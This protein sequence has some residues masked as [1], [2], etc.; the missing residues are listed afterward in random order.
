M[1]LVEK[2]RTR[3]Y[4]TP[5]TYT[6]FNGGINTNLS[7]EDLEPNELRDGLNCHY[8]NQSLMNRKGERITNRLLLPIKDRPQG[9]FL[10][11]AEHND[12]ILCVRNGRIYWNNYN[13]NEKEI[14]MNLLPLDYVI[15]TNN[16]TPIR[17]DCEN[18]GIDLKWRTTRHDPDSPEDTEGYILKY[19]GDGT[20]EPSYTPSDREAN[21]T[22]ICQNTRR[23]QAVPVKMNMNPNDSV[24]IPYANQEHTYL[25]MATGTRLLRIEETQ[26]I[27]TNDEVFEPDKMY[28]YWDYRKQGWV[29]LRANLDYTAGTQYITFSPTS[30]ASIAEYINT[31]HRQV[32]KIQ[33]TQD[34]TF[35]ENETY[36]RYYNNAYVAL[37]ADTDYTVGD[38]IAD[39]EEDHGYK[40]Y[41]TNESV[42]IKPGETTFNSSDIYSYSNGTMVDYFEEANEYVALTAGTNYTVGNPIK[43]YES[44]TRKL[45]YKYDG[46]LGKYVKPDELTF[47]SGTNYFWKW[48]P[49]VHE[50]LGNEV[51]TLVAHI[52]E[53]Y[54]PNSWEKQNIGVNNLSPY[55]NY[56]LD[57]SRNTPKTLI[58][59]IAIEPKQIA[60]DVPYIIASV[61]VNCLVN[62]AKSDMYYKW[63][64]RFGKDS[65]WK[66]IHFWNGQLNQSLL[67]KSDAEMSSKNKVDIKLTHEQLVLL[68][69]NKPLSE[70]DEFFIRCTLTSDFQY[71]YNL[72]EDKYYMERGE[73]EYYVD[74][75]GNISMTHDATDPED[76][77]TNTLDYIADQSIAQYSKTF[78]SRVLRSRYDPNNMTEG[79]HVPAYYDSNGKRYLTIGEFDAPADRQFLRMHSCVKIA[80]DGTKIIIYDDMYDS[81]EW[82][83]SVV[84]QPNYISYGGN[85]NFKTTKDE[86]LIGIVIF[87]SAIVVFSD[88]DKLGGNISVVTGNGDDYND[89][90]YYSPYKRKIVNTHVSCDAYNTIQVFENNIIFKYREDIYALDT[91]DLNNDKVEVETINDKVKTRLNMIEFPLNRI[92]L[93]YEFE[94][95]DMHEDFYQYNRCLKPDEI[96][97][98][99]YDGYYGIIFPHQASH[100]DTF[101]YPEGALVDYKGSNEEYIKKLH[102]NKLENISLK[103]GL[104][105]KCYL[106]NG[107]VYNNNPKVFYPWLRDVSHYLNI[108]G[109]LV[110]NGISTLVTENGELIQFNNDD[111]DGLDEYNYRVR[112]ATK[113]YDMETPALCKFMD[114]LNVYYNRDFLETFYC[115]MYVKNEAGFYIY[116]PNDEAY[117]SMQEQPIGEVKYDERYTV[118]DALCMPKNKLPLDQYD[119]V[120][121][122]DPIDKAVQILNDNALDNTVLDR[123]NFTS[124][125]LTPK[126]RFPFLSAQFIMEIRSNQAFALSSLQFSF[127]SHDMPDF[128]REKLYR[129]I[130]KGNILQ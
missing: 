96:F 98:E 57:E 72:S 116:T 1:S 120:P 126:Y 82:Y 129:D 124:K 87:D 36:Y 75:N 20:T 2:Y 17:D 76:P 122:V 117:V 24:E 12:Y 38:S 102:G 52:L 90:D 68:N 4:D 22:L 32:Y 111:Y 107:Q 119:E 33:S 106:R 99:V 45:V 39:W 70:N 56:W 34:E 101:E 114:N 84:G 67:G 21:N 115:D 110:I 65:D 85:L 123:P 93:P 50:Y 105:W 118:D 3:V 48:S 5:A 43:K 94:K 61:K 86:H 71:T 64:A 23:V 28:F 73:P 78:V 58:G 130:L 27:K 54:K 16:G 91:N 79:D 49:K 26:Y 47:Q 11:S 25:I 44:K 127:T 104:R 31:N 40:V 18:W 62:W 97:S 13:P 10:F 41:D 109:Q 121:Y 125:T 55:P 9:D 113:C 29:M 74:S 88:N 77:S 128:T 63:E 89:G 66:T 14:A 83:K 81:C 92:R 6:Q 15:P 8:V 59:D 42:Y 7:N 30:G 100:V 46:T 37:V 60:I 53:A 51:Y 35:Q 19:V 108:V 112:I 69:E 80:S 95:Q 103:P